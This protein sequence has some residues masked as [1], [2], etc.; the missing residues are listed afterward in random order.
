MTPVERV[1]KSKAEGKELIEYLKTFPRFLA[2]CFGNGDHTA[3][4]YKLLIGYS[5]R[6]KTLQEK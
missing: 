3:V 2:Y 5:L 6:L 4:I 1:E